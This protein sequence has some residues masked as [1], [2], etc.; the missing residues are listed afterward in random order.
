MVGVSLSLGA[1]VLAT[2]CLA[3]WWAVEQGWPAGEV[4]SLGF[5]AIVFGNIAMIH[6]TR[7][8]DHTMLRSLTRA[9]P[10]LWWITGLTLAALAAA[11][12]LQP[13]A[14]VFRFAPLS[15]AGA[16]VAALSGIGGVLWYEA[17]KLLR[18]RNA[19]V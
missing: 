13:L 10:A 1:A 17:Y 11:I 5:A 8:R 14:D 2:V 9:N 6:A 4:R 12:Y 18:P 3:C 15:P 7:S 16:A 19:R